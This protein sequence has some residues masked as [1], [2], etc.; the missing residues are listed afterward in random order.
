[1]NKYIKWSLVIL[2]LIIIFMFSNEQG[3]ISNK[4]SKLIVCLFS[5]L[6]LN[7]NSI[8]GNMANFIVRK[9][10]HFSE[11]FILYIL[12]LN[13]LYKRP[14]IKKE[15]IIS[16]IVVF[17]YSC[18]DEIHQFFIYGRSARIRDVII[19]TSGGMT[20]LIFS[21]FYIKIKE[22]KSNPNEMQSKRYIN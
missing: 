22:R 10:S 18:S 20:A 13:A 11:Y 4:N 15:I 5:R 9:I 17:L 6:G 1:M 21:F 12:I 7:L 14:K 16:I 3:S 19:D 8:F 2:W